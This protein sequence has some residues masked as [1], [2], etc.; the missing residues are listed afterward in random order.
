MQSEYMD[1][2]RLGFNRKL[3]GRP[4]VTQI[5]NFLFLCCLSLLLAPAH[6]EPTT[7][8][9]AAKGTAKVRLAAQEIRR[10]F[11]LRTGFLPDI[12]AWNAKAGL[13]EITFFLLTRSDSLPRLPEGISFPKTINQLEKDGFFLKTVSH[14]GKKIHLIV[15]GDEPGLLYGAYAFAEQMGIRFYLHGDVVPDAKI[16]PKS[17]SATERTGK[18]LFSIRGIQPFH[19]FPE[20]PDWWTEDDY[21]AVFSQLS[22]LKMNF[23]GLHTYPEGGVGPEPLVWIGLKEEIDGKGNVKTAYRSRHFTN[24]NGTW[25]YVKRL[26]SAY[27]NR[28]GD[29]FAEDVFGTTYMKGSQGWPTDAQQ[30]SALFNKTGN[31]FSDV[32]GYARELGIRTCVG[33][34]TP[35]IIPAQVKERLKTKGINPD[36]PAATQLLYEGMFER[37]KRRYPVDY[38]WFWTPEDW[39]WRQNTPEELQKTK[40]D[41]EAAM[42]AAKNVDAPFTLATCGWVLGPANDRSFFDQILPKTWPM[43][44]INRYVGFEP[45]EADFAKT[46][47]RPL[48]AIPWLEDDPALLLPQLWA[49]RMRRDAVDAAAY[50]CTGLIGIHWRTHILGPNVSALA[51]AAWEQPWNPRLGVKATP[52]EAAERK[53]TMNLDCPVEDFYRD[54]AQANFGERWADALGRI[55]SKLDG[56]PVFM[57]GVAYTTWLPRP[58]DW[59]DG[60][61]GIKPDTLLWEKRKNDYQ[62]IEELEQIRRDVEG[63]GNLERFDYWLNTFKYLRAVGEFACTEGEIRRLIQTV[64]KEPEEKRAAY[65]E[66]FI[67]LRKRHIAE[68]ESAFAWLVRSISTK[69]DLGTV[70]NWQQHIDDVSLERPAKEIEKLTGKLLPAECRPGDK[71]LDVR[72]MIVPTVRTAL[73]RGESLR[74]EALF[75]GERPKSVVVKWRTLGG[76]AYETLGFEHHARNVYSVS[77]PAMKINKDFE[78]YIDAEGND[79]SHHLF[80]A[81]TPTIHQTVVVY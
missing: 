72:R 7:I 55:F 14:E 33:T 25:G 60:P 81:T 28:L 50:G 43:S 5:R 68:M 4:P 16:E 53:K 40:G 21:K 38:Y 30:E 46:R 74:L 34:E 8:Y 47:G 77:I 56:G 51:A 76:S 61:G 64:Q 24:V 57:P 31:F 39:T 26:T 19:D 45:I 79:G 42:R 3:Q 58:A 52:E 17:F 44:C 32:F 67:R 73:R 18:P 2:H 70:A 27:S 71:Q 62:F 1:E 35:L 48:W 29:L 78:Y 65:R 69:G 49:G 22:K 20:G 63:E 6:A 54:W 15:G 13:S 10:Y 37:V 75:Y 9:V 59:M 12:K 66:S 80:P 36:D 11:Y 41:L 23:F